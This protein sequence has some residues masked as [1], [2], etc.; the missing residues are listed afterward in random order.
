MRRNRLQKFLYIRF[1]SSYDLQPA[2][3]TETACTSS[4]LGG[5][6]HAA[7]LKDMGSLTEQG[8]LLPQGQQNGAVHGAPAAAQLRPLAFA[9][10]H[11][12]RAARLPAALPL[13]CWGQYAGAV[14]STHLR[15]S[16]RYLWRFAFAMPGQS[17]HVLQLSCSQV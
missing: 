14:F 12:C 16:L 5:L 17:K 6:C 3:F 10:L 2:S 13:P 9:G 7:D 1:T 15:S 4:Y 8:G 11:F